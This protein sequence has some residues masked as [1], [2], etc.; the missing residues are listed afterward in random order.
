MLI[1]FI[2]ILPDGSVAKRARQRARQ[3]VSV[4]ISHTHV[5]SQGHLQVKKFHFLSPI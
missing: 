2:N 1:S 5:A 4:T 3:Q